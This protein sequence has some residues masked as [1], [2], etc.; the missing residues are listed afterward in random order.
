[1][2]RSRLF[3][4]RYMAR[5]FTIV[6]ISRLWSAVRKIRYPRGCVRI[7]QLSD[8]TLCTRQPRI[9]C[10]Q[11]RCRRWWEFSHWLQLWRSGYCRVGQKGVALYKTGFFCSVRGS[12]FLLFTLSMAFFVYGS[13][14]LVCFLCISPLVSF[15][16]PL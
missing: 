1:M 15:V 14:F 4:W 12:G 10:G 9:R 11:L 16:F 13:P 3:R 2:Q 8:S 6:P 7:R 5:V